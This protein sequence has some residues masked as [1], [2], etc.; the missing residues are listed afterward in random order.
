VRRPS[1]LPFLLCGRRHRALLGRALTVTG[2]ALACQRECPQ[3]G[4]LVFVGNP[5]VEGTNDDHEWRCMAA[6][7]LHSLKKLDGEV[8]KSPSLAYGTASLPQ[9]RPRPPSESKRHT[10][11]C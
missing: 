7:R 2:L 8:P 9:P 4:D 1:L 10:S 6:G 11:R 5:L 3:L